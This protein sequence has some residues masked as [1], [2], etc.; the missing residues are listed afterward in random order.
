MLWA[1]WS[2]IVDKPFWKYLLCHWIVLFLVS[3]D[4]FVRRFCVIDQ[5]MR[6]ITLMCQYSWQAAECMAKRTRFAEQIPTELV[7]VR[8]W[9]Y[10]SG[11]LLIYVRHVL[12]E[13]PGMID[14][15]CN[16]IGYLST[17]IVE[18]LFSEGHQGFKDQDFRL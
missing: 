18:H 1:M 15:S 17:W 14:K 16:S 6:K 9:S 10:V 5:E 7:L 11:L 12:N 13:S 3:L 8:F 2:I 4:N